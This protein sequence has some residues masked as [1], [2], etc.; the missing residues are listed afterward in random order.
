MIFKF[1]TN[2]STSVDLTNSDLTFHEYCQ[3]QKLIHFSDE[4]PNFTSFVLKLLNHVWIE[5][6]FT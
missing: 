1:F 6:Y 5:T 2:L 4:Y 3:V